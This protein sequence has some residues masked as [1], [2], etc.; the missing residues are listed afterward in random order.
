MSLANI[1]TPTILINNISYGIKPNSFSYTEGFG[2]QTVSS[3]SAGGASVA[4]VYSDN[5]EMKY[6]TVKFSMFSINVD[7]ELVR[8]WKANRN[9]NV[10]EAIDSNSDFARTFKAAVLTNDYEVQLSF[11]GFIE[12][13]WKTAPAQ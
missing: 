6:S 10:I 4:Q 9:E 7:I 2:E 5:A 12:L 3:Q 13:E 11:D 1:S 8:S